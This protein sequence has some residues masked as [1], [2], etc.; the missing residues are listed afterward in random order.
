V[1]KL[2]TCI[3]LDFVHVLLL[4]VI[5]R[6]RLSIDK[7]LELALLYLAVKSNVLIINLVPA[8]IQLFISK[9]LLNEVITTL[10][11]QGASLVPRSL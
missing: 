9:F 1:P 6:G 5:L 8:S 4:L 10:T 2:V 3:T 11:N 7:L